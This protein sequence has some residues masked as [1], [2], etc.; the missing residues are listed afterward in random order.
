MMTLARRLSPFVA[1]ALLSLAPAAA[2]AADPACRLAVSNELDAARPG[3]TVEFAAAALAPC[4]KA[5]DLAKVHV[6]EEPGGRELL[7]QAVDADSDWNPDQLVSLV[8]QADFA[9]RQRR[10]FRLALGEQ[11]KPGRDQY[12]AYG[13]FVRER[14]DDFAWENDRVAFRMYGAALET[15]EREPLTSSAVDAW[16]KKTRRLVQNDW[17]MVDDYHK[18]HGEG[19]DF[20]PAGRSRGCG[21]NGIWKDG[22]L[23]VSRNFRDSR[24]LANGPIRVVFELTYLGWDVAGVDVAE[25][26]RVTLDAGSNLSRFESLYTVRGKGGFSWASGIRKAGDAQLRVARELGIVR[27]WEAL[28]N[29]GDN[30]QLGC[31]IVI[32]PARVADV[33]EADGNVLVVSR[34]AAPA[35]YYAGSGWSRSG[36]FPDVAAWDRYLEEFARRVASPLKIEIPAR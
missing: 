14:Y 23:Y 32:D 10:E 11:P 27:T 3:E 19:G 21:G 25:R 30:G 24:V 33:V 16:Q 26:K 13:R 8:F 31:G 34:P 5:S 4:F 15:W 9:P 2:Q 12:R 28:K 35:V 17:Y 29:Y 20:Y 6:F 18:D 7:V 22:R 36:D 1:L